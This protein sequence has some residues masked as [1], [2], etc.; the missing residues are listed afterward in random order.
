MAT[1]AGYAMVI[2]TTRETRSDPMSPT[3]SIA[4]K[5]DLPA[6]L[7]IPGDNPPQPCW[8]RRCGSGRMSIET[9]APLRCHRFVE[10]QFAQQDASTA[11]IK[12]MVMSTSET[13]TTFAADI[14]F[15]PPL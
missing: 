9:P 13:G 6:W 10:V 2:K 1:E 11:S 3:C 12:G 4:P 8:I 14:S 5:G 15:W 7:L